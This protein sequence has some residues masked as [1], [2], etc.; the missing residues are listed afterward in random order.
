M[1]LVKTELGRQALLCRNSNLTPR[2]RQIMILAN[3]EQ[4][5]ISIEH[6]MH[7]DL[8]DELE[9]LIRSGYVEERLEVSQVKSPSHKKNRTALFSLAPVVNTHTGNFTSSLQRAESDNQ[10]QTSG[11]SLIGTK[12]YVLDM[13]QLLNNFEA[14]A[15][16]VSIRSSASDV[17]LIRNVTASVHLIIQMVGPANGLKVVNKVREILPEVHLTPFCELALEIESDQYEA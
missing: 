3:G 5:R 15:M 8:G 1:T 16:A 17:E 13:L 10:Q 7:R 6:L 4:S 9:H 14:S 2:E 12:S 11:R